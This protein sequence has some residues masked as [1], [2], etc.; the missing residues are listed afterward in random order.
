MLQCDEC[1]A[2]SLALVV[3]VFAFLVESHECIAQVQNKRSVA[4]Y[5]V[6]ENINIKYVDVGDEVIQ[7]LWLIRMYSRIASHEGS[8]L[9]NVAT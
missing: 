9:D 1:T 3:L 4:T 8:K 6:E 2:R 7:P 5:S